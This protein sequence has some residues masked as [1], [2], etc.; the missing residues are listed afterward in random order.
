MGVI[1]LFFLI[2]DSAAVMGNAASLLSHVVCNILVPCPS[3]EG[4]VYDVSLW[5][6]LLR[7]AMAAGS[8]HGGL[9]RR[10]SSRCEFVVQM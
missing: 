8:D 5:L 10:L 4:K 9:R 3:F 6:V 2:V 7:F 1:I